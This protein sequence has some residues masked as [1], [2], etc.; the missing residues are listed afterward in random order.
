MQE[1]SKERDRRNARYIALLLM[2][3]DLTPRAD[4]LKLQDYQESR[5]AMYPTFIIFM[6]ILINF[7]F[8]IH[9]CLSSLLWIYRTDAQLE[10]FSF[11]ALLIGQ[12]KPLPHYW[13]SLSILFLVFFF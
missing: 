3:H 4:K 9:A 5:P 10:L 11:T 7:S 13:P 1:T 12:A 2:I 6:I 8:S